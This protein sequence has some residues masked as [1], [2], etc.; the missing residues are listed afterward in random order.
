MLHMNVKSKSQEFS[1]KEDI[2]FL[3]LYIYVHVGLWM[4]FKLMIISSW[5]IKI[6]TIM[7]HTLN[8]SITACYL[9]LNT[10]GRERK[11]KGRKYSLP[12]PDDNLLIM[13]RFI[14]ENEAYM[15][16]ANGMIGNI[17]IVNNN[18]KKNNGPDQNT[19]LPK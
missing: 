4:F 5:Y 7:L 12:R 13:S 10:T 6:K 1:S 18:W 2:F 3:F 15:K 19:W 11:K 9:Y 14:R 8:L 16:E 17:N